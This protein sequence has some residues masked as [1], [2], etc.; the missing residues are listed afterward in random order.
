MHQTHLVANS[1]QTLVAALNILSQH[2][3]D[4]VQHLRLLK[5]GLQALVDQLL[6]IGVLLVEFAIVVDKDKL[7]VRCLFAS[8][9]LLG[10]IAGPD[11]VLGSLFHALV[12]S[13]SITASLLAT[14][15]L[16]L[17]PLHCPLD[18]CVTCLLARADRDEEWCSVQLVESP[19]CIM[20]S[21]RNTQCRMLIFGRITHFVLSDPSLV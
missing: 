12:H 18:F 9:D 13:E 21:Q 2:I 15:S 1:V 7:L 5:S 11:K 3:G 20:V 19:V 10:S 4:L 16:F 6:V 17:A 14:L 8:S